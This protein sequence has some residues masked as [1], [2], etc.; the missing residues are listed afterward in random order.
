MNKK[1]NYNRIQ[2]PTSAMYLRELKVGFA[3]Q[4]SCSSMHN[5]QEVGITHM[6][7]NDE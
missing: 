1:Q 6:S 7:S 2:Y 5:S 3:Y 4:H